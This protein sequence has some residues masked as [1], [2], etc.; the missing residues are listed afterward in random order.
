MF[1]FLL[2]I[3]IFVLPLYSFLQDNIYDNFKKIFKLKINIFY[4]LYFIL[5]VFSLILNK[6]S[7]VFLYFFMILL[8]IISLLKKQKDATFSNLILLL[9]IVVFKY[10]SYKY[11]LLS[12][13]YNETKS[14]EI[15]YGSLF[16]GF[17][18]FLTTIFY[19]FKIIIILF[20][21]FFK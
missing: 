10:I 20:K 2:F 21:K 16:F 13:E 7:E 19:C 6:Y 5:F 18:F 3:P 1:D 9:F 15:F 14:Y 4:G 12:I 11:N 17:L 8:L